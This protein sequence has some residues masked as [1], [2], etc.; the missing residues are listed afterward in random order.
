MRSIGRPAW[1]G[2][3]VSLAVS[4]ISGV[5]SAGGPELK[6][7]KWEFQTSVRMPM[8]SEPQTATRTECVK[9]EDAK[10]P[11]K[12]MGDDE[13]CTI[14]NRSEAGDT[15]RWTMTCKGQDGGPPLQGS[16]EI[17]A[18]DETAQGTMDMIISMGGQ[19]MTVKTSW[20]GKRL[21]DCD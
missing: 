21:G 10:D 12:A 19:E 2:I 8:L 9:E 5:A 6:A 14:Q 20:T 11:L 15:L 3:A 17:T 4:L 13:T 16:G 7:G 18:R 1:F